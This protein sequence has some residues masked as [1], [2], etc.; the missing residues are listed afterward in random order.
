MNPNFRTNFKFTDGHATIGYSC[1]YE[2]LKD[3][4]QID[5]EIMEERYWADTNEDG[6][7]KRRRQAEF[8]I[9]E[10]CPWELIAEIGVINRNIQYQVQEILQNIADLPP[11]RVQSN[12][13][14]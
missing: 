3:L 13:Y 10:C 4:E 2:D 14:Y 1:F 6:D 5:W 11:V 12:W 8:L 7:R 9:Y